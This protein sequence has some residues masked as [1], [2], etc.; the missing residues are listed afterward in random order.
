MRFLMVLSPPHQIREKGSSE[1]ALSVRAT[2]PNYPCHV[3]HKFRWPFRSGFTAVNPLETA[4]Q[5]QE[6]LCN[7]EPVGS[8]TSCQGRRSLN[9]LPRKNEMEMKYD[10]VKIIQALAGVL[11]LLLSKQVLVSSAERSFV[12][13]QKSLRPS[14]YSLY[15]SAL[16]TG[17][18]GF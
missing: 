8:A 17:N 13:V 14:V 9:W 3:A 16:E 10:T 11:L 6:R 4:L 5:W 18:P 1:I 7:N 2:C 12:Q 15:Q